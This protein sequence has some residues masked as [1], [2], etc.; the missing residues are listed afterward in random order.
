MLGK[1]IAAG[2]LL[3]AGTLVLAENL[4]LPLPGIK[5][6]RIQA[7]FSC[8]AEGVALGLPSHDFTVE[9]LNAGDNH[10][11]LVP[12][13]GKR[14]IFV[15][16]ISGSGA[17][18]AAGQYIWWDAGSRGVSLSAEATNGQPRVECHAVKKR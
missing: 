18:Y 15:N 12:I 4:T 5:V 7:T 11:A 1:A 10:L 14:M 13:H 8:G 3:C 16:V 9:Y 17:R 6:Q 2:I